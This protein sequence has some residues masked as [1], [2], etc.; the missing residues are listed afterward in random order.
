M[1]YYIVINKRDKQV[2]M[3][4]AQSCQA[5][6]EEEVIKILKHNDFRLVF[7]GMLDNFEELPKK[8]AKF[9]KIK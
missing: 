3:I 6:T 1:Y 7:N 4:E 9:E 2:F 8:Y 5:A